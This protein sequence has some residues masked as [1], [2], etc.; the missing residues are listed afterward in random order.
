[1]ASPPHEPRSPPP[2]SDKEKLELNQNLLSGKDR[3]GS[4]NTSPSLVLVCDESELTR[5]TIGPFKDSA[6]PLGVSIG[7]HPK[8]QTIISLAIVVQ[9]K[10]KRRCLIIQFSTQLGRNVRRGSLIFDTEKVREMIQEVLCRPVGFYAFDLAPLALALYRDLGIRIS[11]GVDVQSAL[12]Q[13]GRSEDRGPRSRGNRDQMPEV[14]ERRK[15][16]LDAIS[17][18]IGGESSVQLIRQNITSAFA[19]LT[20]D[21]SAKSSRLATRTQIFQRAWAAQFLSVFENASEAFSTVPPIDTTVKRFPDI[22]LDILAK[23]AADSIRLHYM[24]SLETVHEVNGLSNDSNGPQVRSSIYKNKLRP[25]RQIRVQLSNEN[26]SF[27]ISGTT[28]GVEGRSAAFTML[29]KL[30]T[31][32]IPIHTL[33]IDEASQ[34]EIGDYVPVF[35]KAIGTLQKVCLIGD[36]KQLPPHGQEDIQSLQSV[37]EVEHF[38]N[39]LYLLDT[40]YRMPPQMG[41]FISQNVYDGLLKSNPTHPITN[42]TI[43]CRFINVLGN[44]QMN[45]GILSKSYRIVTPYDSQ[46]NYIENS[47]KA[48]GL[49]WEDKVFN[50]DSF[51][52]NE[53]NYIIVSIVRSMRIGFLS[54]LRRTNVMLTRFK[55][56]MFI[57]TSKKFVTGPGEATLVGQLA[58]HFEKEMGPEVWMNLKD[59]EEGKLVLK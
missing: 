43:A 30:F 48:E 8:D 10:P 9:G 50:V 7:L 58:S 52:G 33:V 2:S 44:E 16:P 14:R 56:G 28:G 25:D 17:A 3:Y 5:G 39:H 51:Q 40:Q 27:S 53:D 20:Y 15:T 36:D 18:I 1:M 6:E 54:N 47:M 42:K 35:M 57:V 37:F 11:H 23:W 26:G 4:L 12:P 24:N 59:M 31:R 45:I 22:K 46:R 13:P 21:M 55:R 34:I 29:V 38:K 19:D 32:A 41:D 49:N